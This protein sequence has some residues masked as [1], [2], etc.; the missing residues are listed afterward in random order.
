[1]NNRYLTITLA[2]LLHAEGFNK[3]KIQV[4]ENKT[5]TCF[6][7]EKTTST[8]GGVVGATQLTL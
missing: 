1:M 3:T 4:I 6:F 2:K 8:S 5:S 7:T